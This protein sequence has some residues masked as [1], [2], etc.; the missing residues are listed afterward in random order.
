V[1]RGAV[2]PKAAKVDLAREIVA[3]FHAADA[4]RRAADDFE[5][6][7]AKRDLDAVDLPVVEITLDGP[8]GLVTRVVAT[9]GL[10]KS[11]TEAR[12][13]IAQGGVRVDREKIGD[14]MAALGPGEYLVQVGK[15]RAA[16]VV[17]RAR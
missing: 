4:A 14:P 12:K 6:R 15:L 13:L 8:T 11:A 1:E 17:L 5:R 10:A 16:R 2:H 7:F 3:R 9:A